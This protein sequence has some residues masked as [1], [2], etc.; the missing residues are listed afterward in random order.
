MQ[1]FARLQK[2][3]NSANEEKYLERR[4]STFYSP[5]VERKKDPSTMPGYDLLAIPGNLDWGNPVPGRS[6]P[7]W[8]GAILA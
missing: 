8:A 2:L 5:V 4:E 1:K 3:P 7:A 6:Q